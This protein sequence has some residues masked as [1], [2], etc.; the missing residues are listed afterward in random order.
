MAFTYTGGTM[1]KRN[2]RRRT[3]L[4]VCVVTLLLAAL[5]FGA[6]P[7]GTS[8]GGAQ[9]GVTKDSV[10]V[11]IPIIDWESI[12]DF[13]DYTFGD[14]EAVSRVFVDNINKNG[15]INGRKLIPV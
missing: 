9:Q 6:S 7:R 10:K 5:T 4:T 13:V 15:G 14:S 3:T 12:K 2:T 8:S 11:G 1:L